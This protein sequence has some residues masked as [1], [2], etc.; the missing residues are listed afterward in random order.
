MG[1]SSIRMEQLA[2]FRRLPGVERR[3]LLH[4]W[5]L[6][7]VTRLGLWFAPLRRLRAGLNWWANQGVADLSRRMP[8]ERVAWAVLVTAQY[9]PFARSC[10]IRSLVA[11]TLL[12][13]HGHPAELRIGVTRTGDGEFKAHAWVT[14]GGRILVGEQEVDRF[15]PLHGSAGEEGPEPGAD[16]R[17]HREP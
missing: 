3:L 7:V 8:A 9:V 1:L 6:L 12:R 11:H 10:L 16:S 5:V 13:R 4:S 15:L 2:R 14:S 17:P